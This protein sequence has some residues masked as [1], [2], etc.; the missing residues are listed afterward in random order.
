MIGTRLD[1]KYE[2]IAKL[3]EGGMGAVYE[4]QHVQTK[5]RVAIKVILSAGSTD[6]MM[7]ARFQREAR[8]AGSIDS[9]HIA[10]V[11]DA[12]SDPA[13]GAPYLVMELLK[14]QDVDHIMKSGGPLRPTLALRIVAQALAGLERA[15]AA[16][17]IHRDIKPANLFV[18]EGEGDERVV[19]LVDFGVAKVKDDVTAS[20]EY[21]LTQTSSLLGSP[22]YM[23]PEQARTSKSVDGR[24][25]VWSLGTVLYQLIAGE[26]PHHLAASLTE[27]LLAICTE[28]APPIQV[29][30]PWVTPDIAAI[31]MKT[32][33][34]DVEK[35]YATAG[36]VLAD[37]A[38][39]VPDWQRLDASMFTPMTDDERNFVAPRLAA[40]PQLGVSTGPAAHVL[41]DV[42]PAP[43]EFG[44]SSMGGA[45][46]TLH[47]EETA[48]GSRAISAPGTE[49]VPT[50]SSSQSRRPIWPYAVGAVVV[51]TLVGVFA[52]THASSSRPG[53]T[54]GGIELPKPAGSLPDPGP[55]T[56]PTGAPPSPSGPNG[57]PPNVAVPGPNGAPPNV[58]PPGSGPNFAP[59]NGV[60]TGPAPKPAPPNGA[61]GPKSAPPNAAP[62]PKPAAP[63]PAP[64][65]TA[66]SQ[67]SREFN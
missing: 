24:A 56:A 65:P 7:V 5:R 43:L 35:R 16:K 50:A 23:S 55:S 42:R 37:I 49:K 19:K 66:S 34:I 57:A 33:Q 25:D 58:A 44:A 21:S 9:R 3:G 17:V 36:A 32:L 11:L 48:P 12:G 62:A 67:I 22:L 13:T 46:K 47:A 40:E 10:Q 14:G 63:S 4:A 1:S 26:A 54:T 53:P 52:F 31:V 60:A 41:S 45:V 20:R 28:P 8:A 29:R 30:A 38:A 18:A 59:P 61:P 51:G 6:A 39:V 64:K 2:I 15:H 27:L